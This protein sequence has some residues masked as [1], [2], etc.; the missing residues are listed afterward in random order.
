MNTS[1]EELNISN[2]KDSSELDLG[3]LEADLGGDIF[4][5]QDGDFVDELD[6]DTDVGTF[7][8]NIDLQNEVQ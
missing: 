8:T 3:D 4:D 6:E 2:N 5:N 1:L 7:D